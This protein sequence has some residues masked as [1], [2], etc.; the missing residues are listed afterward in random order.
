[1]SFS[2]VFAEIFEQLSTE[3]VKN[4]WRAIRNVA[5]DENEV[6][7]IQRVIA[8]VCAQHLELF[9]AGKK[10]ESLNSSQAAV[11]PQFLFKIVNLFNGLPEEHKNYTNARILLKWQV[12]IKDLLEDALKLYPDDGKSR[13]ISARDILDGVILSDNPENGIFKEKAFVELKEKLMN[14]SDN[15]SISEFERKILADEKTGGTFYP[16]L[17]GPHH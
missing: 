10:V 11:F 1:M 9:D 15:A 6:E 2:S 17:Y 16:T 7:A 8:R 4:D 3:H 12:L 14:L 13:K 5:L